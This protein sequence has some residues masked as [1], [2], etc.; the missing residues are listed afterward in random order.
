[1]ERASTLHSAKSTTAGEVLQIA[2]SFVCQIGTPLFHS[3][4]HRANEHP[5]EWCTAK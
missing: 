5:L 4:T 3:C 2:S 1:M